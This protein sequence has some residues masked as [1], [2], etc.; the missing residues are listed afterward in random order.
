MF[1]NIDWSATD[2]QMVRLTCVA[3]V[4]HAWPSVYK[5]LDV[6]VKTRVVQ[7]PV[8]EPHSVTNVELR[9]T[10]VVTQ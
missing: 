3:A 8:S 9:K 5:M 1:I 6:T 7:V 10:S 4:Q 2:L